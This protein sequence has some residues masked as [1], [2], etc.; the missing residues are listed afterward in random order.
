MILIKYLKKIQE[1]I[2]LRQ[3][4]YFQDQEGIVRRYMR[5]KENW[6]NHFSNSKN[7]I[8][9]SAQTKSKNKAVVLGSGWLLDLPIDKLSEQF[10]E[11]IL[12][13]I[14]HPKQVVNRIKKYPNVKIQ[15]ADLTNGLIDFFYKNKGD[16]EIL[17]KIDFD[18]YL[19][20]IPDADFVISLNIMCQLHIILIDFLR[21]H[22]EDTIKDLQKIEQ[23]IQ[24]LHLKAL[25]Q[26][27][28]CL[29]TDFEEEVFNEDND[30]VGVN[31]LIRI[32]LPLGNFKS[33]WQWKFDSSMTYRDDLKTYFNTVA[34]D[35]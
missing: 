31:P 20:A 2:K 5:E 12:I 35:F 26:G 25:P 14:I 33:T 23:Q 11:I 18:K 13:D 24:E 16:K 9:K 6:D 30:L 1:T 3:M 8:L 7:F 4:Q 22:Q 34:I 10:N 32:N 19:F 28:S 29:I 15:K 21:K 27:K 17:N